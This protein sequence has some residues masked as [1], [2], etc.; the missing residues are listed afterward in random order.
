M[1]EKEDG[2]KSHYNSPAMTMGFTIMAAII[3]FSFIGYQIDEKLKTK[4]YPWT[5][6]GVFLGFL[7][8]GYEIWKL[9]KNEEEKEK[10]KKS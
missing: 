8:S 1:D 10:N 6:L 2:P 5:L 3:V 7:Y 4:N 9:I